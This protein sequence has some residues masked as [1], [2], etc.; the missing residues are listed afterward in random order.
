MP[1]D[2][3]CQISHCL[4]YPVASFPRNGQNMVL[5]WPKHGPHM[6]LSHFEIFFQLKLFAF[7]SFVVDQYKGVGEK[8]GQF[9]SH[10]RAIFWPFLGKLGYGIHPELWNFA[11][12][13]PWHIDY[14][15]GRTN[16]KDHVRTIFWPFLGKGDNGIH[17][18]F[19]NLA[20]SIPGH[21]NYDSGRTNL[22][23][24]ARNN[25]WPL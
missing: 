3:R 24:H 7:I 25:F 21:I 1:R 5:L 20:W 14:D 22:K 8:S 11:W 4:V 15:S 19:W 13:L 6:S 16:F 12:S 9:F 10:K 23:N 17:L 18:E 2:V